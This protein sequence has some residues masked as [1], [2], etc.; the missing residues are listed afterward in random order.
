MFI[1]CGLRHFY[2]RNF[3][4]PRH[5]EA[6]DVYY[7][8]TH[9]KKVWD[10]SPELKEHGFTGQSGRAVLHLDKPVLTISID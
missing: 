7:I 6:Q 4:P 9:K 3:K 8:L 1:Y 5:M 2:I 10:F